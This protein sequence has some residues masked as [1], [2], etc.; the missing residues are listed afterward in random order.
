MT[1]DDE[2][3]WDS[4]D[5]TRLY[6]D[7]VNDD[8]SEESSGGQGYEQTMSDREWTRLEQEHHNNGYREGLEIG[9]EH[10]LQQ[11][12]DRGYQEGLTLGR[13]MGLLRGKLA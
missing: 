13:E 3:I 11:G 12:F 8:L 7:R 6:H 5:D 1:D 2:A 4:D 9:K 10:T